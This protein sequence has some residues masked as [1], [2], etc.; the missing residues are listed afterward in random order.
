VT[1]PIPVREQAEALTPHKNFPCLPASTSWRDW[2]F[3]APV[4][5]EEFLGVLKLV[6]KTKIMRTAR[7]S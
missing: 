7:E 6:R 4:K 2:Q 3:P 5:G 1:V